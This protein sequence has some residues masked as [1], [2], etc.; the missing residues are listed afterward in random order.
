MLQL[1]ISETELKE[2]EYQRYHHPHP[3]VQRKFVTIF[4]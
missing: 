4:R 3:R 2:I 1:N